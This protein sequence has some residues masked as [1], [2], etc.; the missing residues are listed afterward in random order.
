MI[1]VKN[2]D[3]NL[4]RSLEKLGEQ[5]ERERAVAETEAPPEREVVKRSIQALSRDLP[6]EKEKEERNPRTED[7]TLPG[8]LQDGE[9]NEGA[10]KE[11]EDL[12]DMVFEK[13]L[14]VALKEAGKQPPFIEDAF[15]D[16]LVDKLLPELKKR[17]IVK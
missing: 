14:E 2:F 11:V 15:H 16:A 13:G 8:Y 3:E 6:E 10:I 9:R 17:G 12:V 7:S 1:K 5:I 4:E